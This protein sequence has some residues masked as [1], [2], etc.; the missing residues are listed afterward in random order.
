MRAIEILFPWCL[1][2]MNEIID[3]AKKPLRGRGKRG[4]C[5][6]FYSIT[7]ASLTRS[8]SVVIDQAFVAKKI[9]KPIKTPI[10]LHFHW[11]TTTNRDPDN[12]ACGAKFI[13]DGLVWS[14]ALKNDGFYQVNQI[15]HT[16]EAAPKHEQR[17]WLRITFPKEGK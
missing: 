1:P 4:Q 7:K 15:T 2:G 9:Q 5:Q 3:M 17:V 13:L 11:E 8:C 12:V 16:F 14:G 6:S 10:N